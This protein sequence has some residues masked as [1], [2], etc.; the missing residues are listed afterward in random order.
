MCYHYEYRCKV[1]LPSILVLPCANV[2]ANISICS[3]IL[4]PNGSCKVL[5]FSRHSFI[6]WYMTQS[7]N[8][9]TIQN[10]LS[11]ACSYCS[12]QHEWCSFSIDNLLYIGS[13]WVLA[14][15]IYFYIHLVVSNPLVGFNLVLNWA[16]IS[17]YMLSRYD[18]RQASYIKVAIPDVPQ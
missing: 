18:Q 6:V 1:W 10:I 7:F 3:C 11:C 4:L 15:N 17:W 12:Q 5:F 13:L 2:S 9:M 14:K 16:C 8:S